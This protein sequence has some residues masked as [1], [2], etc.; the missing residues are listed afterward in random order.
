MARSNTALHPLLH[1]LA[2]SLHPHTS[3]TKAPPKAPPVAM[4]TEPEIPKEAPP[5]YEFMA[6][7]PSISAI[8][9]DIVKLTAQFVARNGAQFLD[10]L[11]MREQVRARVC[12]G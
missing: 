11:M 9:L 10:K 2:N 7:P 12:I 3:T 8:E 4:V 1:P 5:D 6:E